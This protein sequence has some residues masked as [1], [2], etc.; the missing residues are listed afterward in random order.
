MSENDMGLKMGRSHVFVSH[1]RNRREQ[2]MTDYYFWGLELLRTREEE[3]AVQC[4][5][6][7]EF[8]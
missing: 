6:R 1:G 8:P 5:R 3:D 2:R 7:R 4:R